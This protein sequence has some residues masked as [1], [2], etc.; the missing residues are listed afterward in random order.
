MSHV[1][2]ISRHWRAINAHKSMLKNSNIQMIEGIKM[3]YFEKN[4]TLYLNI[5][6]IIYIKC[7]TYCRH[8]TLCR[9]LLYFC[10]IAAK[11]ITAEGIKLNQFCLCRLN[12]KLL[13]FLQHKT[14]NNLKQ[15][16]KKSFCRR[17]FRDFF[18]Y[19]NNN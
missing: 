15:N 12:I 5:I 13:C 14:G 10:D 17:I 9:F 16:K 6:F 19:S 2:N 7:R 8:A 18:S 4:C 1:W 11:G 3:N